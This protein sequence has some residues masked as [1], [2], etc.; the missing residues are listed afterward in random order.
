MARKWATLH[1]AA[2]VVAVLAGID[3]GALVAQADTFPQALRD[4][5]GWRRDLADQAID[6]I[7]AMME[8]GLSALLTIYERGGDP[9]APALALWQEFDRARGALLAMAPEHL[10]D[11]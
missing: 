5:A 3:A 1:E 11:A 2:A 4:G 9:A 7:A 10:H 8:P 6:D